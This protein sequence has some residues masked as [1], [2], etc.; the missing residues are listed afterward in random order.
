[1]PGYEAC[2][3]RTD[4]TLACWG[5][6]IAKT[7][8]RGNWM[9]PPTAL[10]PDMR[11]ILPASGIPEIHRGTV[12]FGS[13][14]SGCSVTTPSTTFSVDDAIR[15]AA[16]LEREVRAGE[17]VTIALSVNGDVV[18]GDVPGEAMSRTFNAPGDCVAGFMHWAYAAPPWRNL[19]AFPIPWTTGHYLLKLSVGRR[20]LARGE[21]DVGP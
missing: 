8:M 5:D 15:F 4:G 13:S 6:W 3:I 17:I 7:D 16:N 11:G 18:G 1:L 10:I 9:G 21:F 19:S 14:G 2:A 20:V 12:E